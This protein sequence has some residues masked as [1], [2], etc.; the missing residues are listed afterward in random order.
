M[1]AM[2]QSERIP[3]ALLFSGPEAVGKYTLARNLAKSLL[4]TESLD[5]HPDFHVL[6]PPL[7]KTGTKKDIPVELVRELC[8][9]LRLKPFRGKKVVS[10]IN[11]A[12]RLSIS[13]ANAMLMTLE[14]PNDSSHLI[15]VTRAE[16]KLPETIVS[17]TQKFHFG[18]LAND[19][20]SKLLAY[21]TASSLDKETL[22]FLSEICQG[23]L[24]LLNLEDYLDEAK[25]NIDDIEG[26]KTHLEEF[27]L[28]QQKLYSSLSNLF[29]NDCAYALALAAKLAADSDSQFWPSLK[30]L[31]REKL[32]NPESKDFNKLSMLYD[33]AL[34]T[35]RLI[36]ERHLSQPLKLSELF[37]KFP[38][39]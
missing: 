15:L 36:T 5:N 2:L 13:A 30:K 6:S 27:S 16:N 17:R 38:N 25:W 28:G 39:G 26:L 3:H 18:Y 31:L 23:S 8:S 20:I 19:E 34:E 4:E 21:L 1:E 29:D 12:D 7:S 32:S 33:E 10:I 11:D 24:A 22:T 35:E 14:E 9:K 37:I